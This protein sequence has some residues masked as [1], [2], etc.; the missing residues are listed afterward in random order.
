MCERA[1]CKLA[2]SARDAPLQ[3]CKWLRVLAQC[4]R[5]CSRTQ[6][7]T[8]QEPVAGSPVLA[9]VAATALVD[10]KG[11]SPDMP[12]P[13]EPQFKC[14]PLCDCVARLLE[15]VCQHLAL[16]EGLQVSEIIHKLAVVVAPYTCSMLTCNIQRMDAWMHFCSSERSHVVWVHQSVEY[17][18]PCADLAARQAS[19]RARLCAKT[20]AVCGWWSCWRTVSTSNGP[21]RTSGAR[22]R[23]AGPRT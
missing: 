18:V 20:T 19:R 16:P 8:L 1:P 9:D 14:E 12:A 5:C 4:L 7:V 13:P 22:K 2:A 3:G 17:G 21:C 11:L 10:N 15:S 23:S 6:V